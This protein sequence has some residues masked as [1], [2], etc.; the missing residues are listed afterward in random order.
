[1]WSAWLER[2]ETLCVADTFAKA[3][4]FEAACEIVC[5]MR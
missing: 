3:G 1:M 5:G 2:L 4:E